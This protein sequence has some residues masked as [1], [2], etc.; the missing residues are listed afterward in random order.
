MK[1]TVLLTIL[2]V[3]ALAVSAQERN[4]SQSYIEKFKDNAVAI[5]HQSG[6]PAS[7]ILGIAMHESANGN[8]A[9]AKNLNNQFGMKGGTTSVYYKNN[10]KVKSAYKSYDSVLESFEDFARI[11]TEKKKFAH[12]QDQLSSVDYK[13]WVKGIQKAGYASSRKWGAQVLALINKYDLHDYDKNVDST[14]TAPSIMLP[15]VN[16]Q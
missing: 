3:S 2:L 1:K 10:K 16:K 5:M 13:G 14:E 4:T 6:I 7:I 11:M 8:S 12:L 15:P 9:I